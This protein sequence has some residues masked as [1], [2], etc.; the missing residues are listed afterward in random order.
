MTYAGWQDT[1]S[2][3]VALV[4]PSAY[5][6][7]LLSAFISVCAL[8]FLAESVAQARKRFKVDY[9]LLYASHYVV[10]AHEATHSRVRGRVR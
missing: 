3:K 2:A 8:T 6:Y 7:V 10:R 5:G 4:L 1:A 9:P